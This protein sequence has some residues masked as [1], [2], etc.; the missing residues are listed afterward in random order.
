MGIA[1]VFIAFGVGAQEASSPEERGVEIGTIV[2]S[3]IDTA[4]PGIGSIAQAVIDI[5]RPNRNR[6]EE[7]KEAAEAA[8]EKV[9]SELK[10][11]ISGV[12]PLVN[13]L[14][15][16]GTF[17]Q[18]GFRANLSLTALIEF[19]ADNPAPTEA[20]WNGEIRPA[21][22]TVYSSLNAISYTPTQITDQIQSEGLRLMLLQLI[23][24]KVATGSAINS[25]I[26]NGSTNDLV[27]D[28]SKL[29]GTL[30]AL[31]VVARVQLDDLHDQ[32]DALVKWANGAQSISAGGNDREIQRD[33]ASAMEVLASAAE[34]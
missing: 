8:Q 1:L 4:L 34:N 22:A 20:Q 11:K 13:Q 12:E 26:T 30:S 32:V 15:V 23:E 28:L 10:R 33:V 5:V 18:Y 7:A 27:E 14:N 25:K 3:A 29:S 31:H 2:S 21:W 19:V 9:M 6:E 17:L 24:A 16:F